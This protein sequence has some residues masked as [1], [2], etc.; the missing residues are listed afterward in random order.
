VENRKELTDV[1]H[2]A[3][4]IYTKA[5]DLGKTSLR[6]GT[7][8]DKSDIRV[9]AYGAIDELN[10]L[11]GTGAAFLAG[12]SK[13]AGGRVCEQLRSI[14]HDLLDIGSILA[15]PGQQSAGLEQRTLELEEMIDWM[16]EKLPPL[17]QFILP[18]GTVPSGMLHIARTVARR[19][20]RRV[21]FLSR[22]EAVDPF[23]LVYLNR[24]SDALFTMARFVNHLEGQKEN[25]WRKKSLPKA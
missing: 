8:V 20:E 17:T 10:S 18:G 5:G 14:Q 13:N 16:T 11:I 15:N 25:F 22:K 23:V 7:R 9:D 12:S 21:V 4:K 2:K 19:A 3:M 6:N 1:L 24:V